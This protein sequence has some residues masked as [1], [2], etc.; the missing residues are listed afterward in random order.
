MV[1][2]I[3]F[4]R[5]VEVSSS[6]SDLERTELVDTGESS[7]CFATEVVESSPPDPTVL[8]LAHEVIDI[9]RAVASSL[10][11]WICTRLEVK[12]PDMVLK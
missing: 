7:E 8:S 10:W 12:S 11:C 2:G 9:L 6:A 4:L 1:K 3:V 5:V